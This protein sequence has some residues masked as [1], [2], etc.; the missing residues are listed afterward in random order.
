MRPCPPSWSRAPLAPSAPRSCRA[1]GRRDSTSS[2]T[3]GRRRQRA[4]RW[5]GTPRRSSPTSAMR[6]GWTRRW[7]G[8]RR[9]SASSAP[10]AAASPRATRTRAPTTCRWCSLPGPPSGFLRPCRD[11]SCCSR[12]SA[13]APAAATWDGNSRPRKWC[14]RAGCVQTV[15]RP[16]FLD[17]THS[18]SEA[19]DGT[20]RK[21]PPLSG[22][23]LGA[24][25]H[26]PGLRGAA[27]DLRPAARGDALRRH[28]P[29]PARPRA[30]G[31]AQG[32]RP[33]APGLESSTSGVVD[34][35]SFGAREVR[36]RDRVRVRVRVRVC[37]RVLG[38][39]VG[40][41]LLDRC[42]RSV[43]RRRNLLLRRRRAEERVRV[44]QHERV[45]QH[46]VHV[47]D[48]DDR[49]ARAGP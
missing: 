20:Q 4:T 8:R 24:I 46:L 19:S 17:S 40:I 16:S 18:G 27:D 9:W 12:R 15:L 6:S 30:A 26:L 38:S 25:G 43:S 22:A 39:R 31:H 45:A 14:A 36:S 33:L 48:R 13:R 41:G 35:G 5:A 42:L 23:L 37:V 47:L 11:T 7:R 2:P 32:P 44:L 29:H 1:C 21:P 10:C 49:S 34:Q 28:R 3:C